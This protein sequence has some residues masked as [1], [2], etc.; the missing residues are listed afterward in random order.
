MQSEV[1]IGLPPL[2][3]TVTTRII[4]FLVGDPYKPSFATVAGRGDNPRSTYLNILIL[5]IVKQ[6]DFS[7]Q[8]NE[9]LYGIHH[10]K[11]ESFINLN[12]GCLF[13]DRET[14]ISQSIF[15]LMDKIAGILGILHER[16]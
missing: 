2:P 1:Y 11:H 10:N 15:S 5:H 14:M 12:L 6:N 7:R 4:T 16:Y 9:K 13:V 3:V 8:S